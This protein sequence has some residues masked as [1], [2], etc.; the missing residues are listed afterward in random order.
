MY[1][2]TGINHL[3][4][5]L[6]PCNHIFHQLYVYLLVL[7]WYYQDFRQGGGG[8]ANATIVELRGGQGYFKCFIISKVLV[9]LGGGGSGGMLPQ[10]NFYF[11]TSETVFGC[12]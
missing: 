1:S 10:E 6:C 3:D 2:I 8:W 4:R 9:I 5:M 11:S 7:W 12:F